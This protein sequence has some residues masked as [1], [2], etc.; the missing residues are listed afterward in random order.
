MLTFEIG[1]RKALPVRAIPFCSHGS[2]SALNVAA[3]LAN[4]ESIPG[5]FDGRTYADLNHPLTKYDRPPP[6]FRVD[7]LGKIERLPAGV[8]HSIPDTVSLAMES[9]DPIAPI[10]ALPSRFFVWLDEIRV[11]FDYLDFQLTRQEEYARGFVQHFREWRD[12]PLLPMDK[13]TFEIVTDGAAQAVQTAT[14]GKVKRSGPG[15]TDPHT[16][17]IADKEVALFLTRIK[18]PPTKDEIATIIEEKFGLTK[19]TVMREIKSPKNRT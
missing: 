8:F 1:Y 18:R 2:I 9:T 12:E 10:K 13:A 3:F 15:G 7:E 6:A 16:Q 4:P 11:L 5:E 17:A 19:S 14:K